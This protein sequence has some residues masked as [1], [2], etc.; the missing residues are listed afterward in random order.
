MPPGYVDARCVHDTLYE[1]MKVPGRIGNETHSLGVLIYFAPPVSHVYYI[2]C[3]TAQTAMVLGLRVTKHASGA[4]KKQAKRADPG[5]VSDLQA[6]ET[7]MLLTAGAEA[8]ETWKNV[9]TVGSQHVVVCGEPGH[10]FQS[11]PSFQASPDFQYHTTRATFPQTPILHPA[12]QWDSQKKPNCQIGDRQLTRN[13]TFLPHRRFYKHLMIRHRAVPD[14]IPPIPG[15]FKVALRRLGDIVYNLLL[16]K[17]GNLSSTTH[18][19]RVP[20]SAKLP[21]YHSLDDGRHSFDG[22]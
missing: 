2:L 1:R 4:T 18:Q 5:L 22:M 8:W 12:S 10:Q 19:Q 9:G 6:V 11:F 13:I 3:L 16:N 20:L 7:I 14:R 21:P 17:A 15:T